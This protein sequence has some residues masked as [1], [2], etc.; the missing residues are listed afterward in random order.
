MSLL[1]RSATQGAL[2][3]GRAVAASPVLS[4][5]LSI[6]QPQLQLQQQHSAS[7]LSK[8]SEYAVTKVDSLVN[9]A[10]KGSMWPMTFGEPSKGFPACAAVVVQGHVH[11]H[12]MCA[13]PGQTEACCVASTCCV[14]V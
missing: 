4:D 11:L 14:S 12:K 2:K 1:T 5:A 6:Q 7:S 13:G 8:A 10:R 3:A 9:W